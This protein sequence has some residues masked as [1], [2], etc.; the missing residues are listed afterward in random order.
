MGGV[1]V[2]LAFGLY[3]IIAFGPAAAPKSA[4]SASAHVSYD[5]LA[6]RAMR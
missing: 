6:W 3:G 5:T 1:L 2:A 4:A